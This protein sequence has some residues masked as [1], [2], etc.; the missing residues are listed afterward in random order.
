MYFH[1]TAYYVVKCNHLNRCKYVHLSAVL[2]LFQALLYIFPHVTGGGFVL[3]LRQINLH[4]TCALTLCQLQDVG[5]FMD[6]G[7]AE[8]HTDTADRIKNALLVC[9][10]KHICCET[11]QIRTFSVI[12]C[13]T[14]ASAAHSLHLCCGTLDHCCCLAVS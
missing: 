5:V 6:G 1:V 4:F 9:T 7:R 3:M 2:F 10:L 14:T 11:D 8:T 12:D 13:V